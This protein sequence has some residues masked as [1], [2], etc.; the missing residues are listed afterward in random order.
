M[1][2]LDDVH[3]L[4]IALSEE[5]KSEIEA[6]RDRVRAQKKDVIVRDTLIEYYIGEYF[7]I[8]RPEIMSALE[9]EKTAENK[10]LIK[11][12]GKQ[13]DEKGK[14]ICDEV[15]CMS[16]EGVGKCEYCERYVCRSHNYGKPVHSCYACYLENGG[17]P[18]NHES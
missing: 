10:E 9:A 2:I 14:R 16:T 3:R 13:F 4:G 7:T 8:M 17:T 6:I 5:D 11:D 18:V 1:G 15:G 12:L